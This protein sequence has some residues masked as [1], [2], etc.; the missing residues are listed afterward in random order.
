MKLIVKAL[1]AAF[2]GTGLVACSG[3][4]GRQSSSQ[5]PADEPGGSNNAA[6]GDFAWCDSSLSAAQRT[7][8]LLNELT[9]DE[10]LQLM[11]GDDPASAAAG[12]PAVGVANGIKRVGLDTV[13]YS[14]GPVGVRQGASVTTAHPAPMALGASFS[15]Q[16][17]RQTGAAVA[18]EVKHYGNDVVH[19]PTVD[20]VRV[21]VHG[22]VFETY[23]EDPFLAAKLAV[24]WIQGAQA[25]GVIANVKHYAMNNQEGQVGVPPFS[26]LL[27][28]LPLVGGID[29][30]PL[31]GLIGGRFLVSANVEERTLREIYL[32]PFEAAVIAGNVGAVMCA[33]NYVNG[34]PACSSK[35]LLQEILRDEWGFD[36]YVLTD[37]YFAQKDTVKSANNGNDLEMPF[38]LHYTPALLNAAL[39]SGQVVESIIDQRVGNQLRTLVK[40]GVMDRDNYPEDPENIDFAV[41]HAIAR[42]TA[43]RGTVLLRNNG[44][45]PLDVGSLSSI[46]IIGESANRYVNG[47]GSSAVNP[48]NLVTPRTAIN[49]RAG[50][51][52]T[53]RYNDGS[54]ANNA[55]RLAAASD[56]AL[57]FVTDNASEGQDRLCL[58]LSCPLDFGQ[59]QDDLIRAVSAA[60]P[61]TVV[62]LQTGSAVLT[63][64]RNQIAGLLEAWYPGEAGGP[65]IAGIL[66]GDVN[67]S[68][69]LPITF[70]VSENDTPYAND[71]RQYPGVPVSAAGGSVFQT[72]YSEGVLVGYRWYD[73]QG[74][75]PA[76]AFGFGLSYTTYAYSDLRVSG[77]TVTAT[78]TNTGT[79]AGTEIAQ[80]YLALPAPAVDVI[81]PPWKLKGFQRTR[82]TPGQSADVVFNLNKRAFSFWDI[83]ANDWRVAPGC[84]RIAVGRHSRDLPLQRNVSR[85]GGDC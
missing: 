16:L 51:A 54:N 85:A 13:F 2:L 33:Y 80:L 37:Y 60:N 71:P 41:H 10:K 61:D 32:P 44:L 67:P 9:L 78:V 42:A 24:P 57:V 59:D 25:Q 26:G 34:D 66:F 39:L 7:A 3:S 20:V 65:A 12:E 73:Q 29:V 64:W 5:Q 74:I 40:F 11:A 38:G 30:P 35:H 18:D 23:G 58:S 17:A 76:Y 31:T 6:C 84:Y 45:L 8:L 15:R 81:Q 27:D 62:I 75:E 56:V 21:L 53:V 14:D 79:R 1:F 69:K 22:R 49:E 52:A 77:N 48:A 46:A 83:N 70:P 47:G 82:L 50:A 28:D 72:E 36:G 19:A 68:G 55:A 63:P 43:E 4:D